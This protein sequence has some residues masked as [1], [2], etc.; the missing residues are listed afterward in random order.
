MRRAAGFCQLG[1][2][3][4]SFGI[5]VVHSFGIAAAVLVAVCG[6]EVSDAQV[7]RL[8]LPDQACHGA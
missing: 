7:F 6:S 1:Q 2:C 8:K 5:A 4:D 3:A